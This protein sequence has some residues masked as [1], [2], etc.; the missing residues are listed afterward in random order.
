VAAEPTPTRRRARSPFTWLVLLAFAGVAF[1]LSGKAPKEQ[2]VR[3]V[4]GAAAPRLTRLACD[5]EGPEGASRTAE[6]T[7][8]H[9]EAPRVIAHDPELV[10]GDYIL[11]LRVFSKDGQ[12]TLERRVTLSSNT[13]SVDL[14]DTVPTPASSTPTPLPASHP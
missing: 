1:Y 4:L 3:F 7:F 14:A 2:H 6:F 12:N 10:P 8:D 5:Y 9:G 11:H 13:V